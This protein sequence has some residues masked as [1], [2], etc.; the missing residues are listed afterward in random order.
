[1]IKRLGVLFPILTV[2]KQK[3]V[4]F[5]RINVHTQLMIIINH[6]ANNKYSNVGTSLY[7]NKY[8]RRNICNICNIRQ[9]ARRKDFGSVWVCVGVC[10]VGEGECVTGGS[11]G[12][13][14]LLK[15]SQEV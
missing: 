5:R 6:Q 4:Q 14:G 10:G 3:D 9:Q 13:R 15:I 11:V 1:M 7:T 12:T 2:F 8:K